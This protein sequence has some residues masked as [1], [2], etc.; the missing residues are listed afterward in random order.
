MQRSGIVGI[1]TYYPKH[2]IENVALLRSPNVLF[3]DGHTARVSLRF[4]GRDFTYRRASH[5]E[6]NAT[7][8]C[9]FIG[10]QTQ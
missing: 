3:S 2:Y 1:G 4:I 6:K 5:T 8:S 7:I 9:I 10:Y